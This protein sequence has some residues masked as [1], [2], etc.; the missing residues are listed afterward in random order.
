MRC[1]TGWV[2]FHPPGA[3]VPHFFPRQSE[4]TV[5]PK[6]YV[7]VE[8]VCACASP[9]EHLDCQVGAPAHGH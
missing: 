4:N 1:R 8:A 7:H 5:S 2:G 3:A 6:K 9:V